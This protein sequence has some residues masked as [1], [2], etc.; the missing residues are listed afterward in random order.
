MRLRFWTALWVGKII[1]LLIKILGKKGTTF[2]GFVARKICPDIIGH[3]AASFA[4]GTVMITGTNGKT[5][6]NNLLASILKTAGKK[7]AFN[8]EGANMLTGI[9]GALLINTSVS[10]K[11]KASLLLLEV[12]EATVPGLCRQL[13]PRLALLPTFFAISWTDTGSW[14]PL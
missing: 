1:T 7:V 14:I 9:T 11:P 10:G 5:T 3:L 2:P 6:T 8:R 4:E 13:T 12:D